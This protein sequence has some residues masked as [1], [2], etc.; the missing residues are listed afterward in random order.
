MPA[1]FVHCHLH[2]EYSLLDGEG[3]I[4]AVMQRAQKLGMPA[5][6]LTDHGA[7]YGAIEAG[8]TKFVVE[9]LCRGCF[10]RRGAARFFSV[11]VAN[12]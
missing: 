12:A 9:R 11:P 10:L 7:L 2:T 1:E 8:G 5:V 4:A 6:A 3:R